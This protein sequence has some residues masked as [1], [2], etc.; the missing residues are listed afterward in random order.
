[1]FQVAIDFCLLG[2]LYGQRLPLRGFG[3]NTLE[4][5]RVGS[6]ALGGKRCTVG[7]VENKL[8]DFDFGAIGLLG[9]GEGRHFFLRLAAL[10]RCWRFA[11]TDKEARGDDQY[12]RRDCFG[13]QSA[14][15]IGRARHGGRSSEL[16]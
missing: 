7:C 14:T 15:W 9:N 5:V 2:P 16:P 13:G 1:S 12:E 6:A 4:L 3:P 10:G 8:A 11:A